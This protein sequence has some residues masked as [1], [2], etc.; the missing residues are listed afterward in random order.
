MVEFLLASRMAPPVGVAGSVFPV[1]VQAGYPAA[2]WEQVVLGVSS[3]ESPL[4]R[5][6]HLD[7]D[8]C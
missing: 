8:S 4:A 5:P 7:V 1:V 2:H 3:A 6:V